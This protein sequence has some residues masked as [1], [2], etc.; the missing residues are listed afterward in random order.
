MKLHL[1]I[2]KGKDAS[3]KIKRVMWAQLQTEI[4]GME[5]IDTVAELDEDCILGSEITRLTAEMLAMHK[6]GLEDQKKKIIKN[7]KKK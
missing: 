6:K 1:Q 3:G 5:R 7:K 4:K 2:E